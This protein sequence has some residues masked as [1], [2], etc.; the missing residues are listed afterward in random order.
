MTDYQVFPIH[1]S[2]KVLATATLESTEAYSLVR[3]TE[4]GVVSFVFSSG[5]KD[6]PMVAGEV[7]AIGND[8]TI[9]SAT[10]IVMS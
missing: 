4:E 2:T 10:A 1:A 8:C 9:T 6:I 5:T 3:A 7:L